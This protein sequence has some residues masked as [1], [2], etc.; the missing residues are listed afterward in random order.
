MQCTRRLE[1]KA[2]VKAKAKQRIARKAKAK[3]AA[4]I[5]DPENTTRAIVL[6][7]ESTLANALASIVARQV[8]VLLLVPNP[9]KR[10][11]AV[12]TKSRTKL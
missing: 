7:K 8:T 3:A 10:P 1:A 4:S 9:R 6:K 11:S 12:S 2:R 5:V